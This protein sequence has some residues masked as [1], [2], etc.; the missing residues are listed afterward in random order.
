MS[1]DLKACREARKRLKAEVLRLEGA[2]RNATFR[3]RLLV[4]KRDLQ[5]LIRQ[6]RQQQAETGRKMSRSTAITQAVNAYARTA[7]AWKTQGR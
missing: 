5:D 3:L 6:M 2:S 1:E 4:A 7:Q